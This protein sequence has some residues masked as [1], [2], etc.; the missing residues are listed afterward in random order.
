MWEV[1]YFRRQ[2]N[3]ALRATRHQANSFAQGRWQSPPSEYIFPSTI[4]DNL[5]L[6]G[7]QEKELFTVRVPQGWLH[8]VWV[9]QS[10]ML[11][12]FQSWKMPEPCTYR[13]RCPPRLSTSLSCV[14]RG[15]ALVSRLLKALK[16]LGLQAHGYLEGV[17][18]T[19][20]CLHN[21]S[22]LKPSPFD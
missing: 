1:L 2:S 21:H 6:P 14:K 3:I 8:G 15:E 16:R 7:P 9:K 19:S 5:H 13:E 10:R 4:I 22:L 18:G 17:S 12:R 11:R 20:P